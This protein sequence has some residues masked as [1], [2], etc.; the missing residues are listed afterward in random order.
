MHVFICH[1]FRN[2][3]YNCNSS[4]HYSNGW[5]HRAILDVQNV[6]PLPKD[7]P[8]W[9]EPNIFITPHM[10]CNFT[11]ATEHVS[12]FQFNFVHTF[13]PFSFLMH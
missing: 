12:N 4:L 10:S 11:A 1:N 5:L 13:M 9:D 6:E 8:L 3:S 2:K 7:S